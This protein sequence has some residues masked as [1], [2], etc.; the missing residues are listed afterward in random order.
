MKEQTTNT[1]LEKDAKILLL[2]VL[3]KG[4]ITKDEKKQLAKLIDLPEIQ[5]EIIDKTGSLDK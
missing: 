2:K 1:T 5:I 3:K 4:I